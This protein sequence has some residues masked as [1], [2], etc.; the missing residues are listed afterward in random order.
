MSKS[1]EAHI[2]ISFVA[3][4]VYKELERQLKAKGSRWS[5]EKAIEI[6]ETIYSIKLRN[7]ATGGYVEHSLLLTDEQRELM[8]LF[9]LSL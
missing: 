4:K 7:P 1:G 8:T 3:Y 2:C 6:A 9:D 5:V